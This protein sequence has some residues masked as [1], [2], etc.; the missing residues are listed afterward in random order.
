MK[1]K[2]MLCVL[3][4]ALM[5]PAGAMHAKADEPLTKTVL[6]NVALFKPVKASCDNSSY[7]KSNMVDD[8]FSTLWTG[9][10]PADDPDFNGA[11]SPKWLQ[12]DLTAK[13]S[14]LNA[15]SCGTDAMPET[16]RAAANTLR[17]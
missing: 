13:V 2:R 10:I 9:D 11:V 12:V 17:L 15:L 6:A 3:L 16:L 5:L 8:D 4:A 14:G 1:M 7:A